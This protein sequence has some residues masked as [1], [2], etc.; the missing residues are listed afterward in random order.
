M[1][2][3]RGGCG[4]GLRFVDRVE[5]A[6]RLHRG[7]LA[8]EAL[9]DHERVAGPVDL[10][11]ARLVGQVDLTLQQG[12]ELVLG[13][14]DLEGAALMGPEAGGEGAARVAVP[15]MRG[16]RLGLVDRGR[17]VEADR[18]GHR[19]ALAAGRRCFAIADSPYPGDAPR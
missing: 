13:V 6:Q 17:G 12:A 7:P 1:G 4:L 3:F 2:S 9:R 10:G 15:F 5:L 8:L 18:P 19:S 14:G 16:H 11:V